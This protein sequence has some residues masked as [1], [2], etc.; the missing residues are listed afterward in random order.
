M[1]KK[2]IIIDGVDVS[3]CNELWLNFEKNYDSKCIRFKDVYSQCS[4]CKDNHNCEYK[5]LQKEK[6]ENLN[7]RQIVED[8]ENLIYE[9]SE[10]YK[11]LKE[12]E[13]ECEQIKEKYEA[14]KLENQEGYEI[15]AELKH[16]CEELKEENEEIKAQRDTYVNLMNVYKNISKSRQDSEIVIDYI[17][18]LEKKL[19]IAEEALNDIK[20][21]FFEDEDKEIITHAESIYYYSKAKEAL[22]KMKEVENEQK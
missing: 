2:Q 1:D 9:N 16:E 22:Q 6:F 19:K 20:N 14:L 12:K 7:N 15:V 5:Q 8:A 10:L 13:Q 17:D 3:G 4:Y 11:N 21:S 18:K